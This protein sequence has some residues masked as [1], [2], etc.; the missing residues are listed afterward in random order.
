MRLIG[1]PPPSAE[2]GPFPIW[3]RPDGSTTR[4][5]DASALRNPA[6]FPKGLRRGRAGEQNAPMARI[7]AV[8]IGAA[9]IR[10]Y[11]PDGAALVRPFRLRR[12][13][14]ELSSVLSDFLRDLGSFDVLAVALACGSCDGFASRAD[15]MRHALAAIKA[16]AVRC[17]PS[18]PGPGRKRG[19]PEIL[20]WRS[21][22]G[23]IPLGEALGS[24]DHPGAGDWLALALIAG[25]LAPDG[26]AVAVDVGWTSVEIVPLENGI[27]IPRA[28]GVTERLVSGELLYAGVSRTPLAAAVRDLPFRGRRCPVVAEPFATTRDAYLVLGL[29]PE[30]P[31]DSDTADGYPATREM[32]RSRLARMVAAEPG[33]FTEEDAREAARSVLDE[34]ALRLGQSI[35]K[36]AALDDPPRSTAVVA[37]PGEFLARHALRDTGIRVLSFAEA[38][39]EPVS[40]VAPAYAIWRLA[41]ERSDRDASDRS[42]ADRSLADRTISER[43]ISERASSDGSVSGDGEK[44]SSVGSQGQSGP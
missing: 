4:V 20:V 13:P 25:R 23:F 2:A 16:A 14:H 9:V 36:V 18:A 41:T 44:G 11:G 43:G 24:S 7:A 31:T 35:R 37:G 17:C 33:A 38:V 34:Q 5:Y 10:G 22:G 39:G 21:D 1:S 6:T 26:R 27:P 32:A 28:F 3:L 30:D 15:G 12:A 8:D 19:W 42:L 29:L 40:S